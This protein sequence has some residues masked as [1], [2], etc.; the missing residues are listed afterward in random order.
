M[1]KG[2]RTGLPGY[3]GWRT[4]TRT[5]YRSR[6]YPPVRDFEFGYSTKCA[7]GVPIGI[8]RYF[9][10]MEVAWFELERWCV[11]QLRSLKKLKNWLVVSLT[12]LQKWWNGMCTLFF[13][14][15]VWFSINNSILSGIDCQDLIWRSCIIV[16]EYGIG[17][18]NS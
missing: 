4:G 18:G 13:V 15:E 17:K 8:Y 3:I 6:L 2:C 1:V 16:L 10:Q 14:G 5:I 9:F 11:S 7:S 12:W